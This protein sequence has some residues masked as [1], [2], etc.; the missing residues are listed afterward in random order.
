MKLETKMNT[1]R[2]RPD[3]YGKVTGRSSRVRRDRLENY[4]GTVR[5]GKPRG[6]GW[7]EAS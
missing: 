5:Q 7:V 3:H 4:L 1:R 6:A 2:E